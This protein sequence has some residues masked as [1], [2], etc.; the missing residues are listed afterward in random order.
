[1]IYELL[2][3]DARIFVNKIKKKIEEHQKQSNS[4]SNYAAT[5]GVIIIQTTPKDGNPI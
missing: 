1:M 4:L 3:K 2:N 5:L